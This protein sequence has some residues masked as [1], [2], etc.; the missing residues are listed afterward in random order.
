MCTRPARP[1]APKRPLPSANKR[2]APF[3]LPYAPARPGHFCIP[4]CHGEAPAPRPIHENGR[5]HGQP[6]KTADQSMETAEIMD[7]PVIPS[8]AKESISSC[9]NRRDCLPLYR[10]KN[11]DCN[12][13]IVS[14]SAF[15]IIWKSGKFQLGI[16]EEVA[17]PAPPGA[18]VTS[19]L[20][21]Q[22]SPELPNTKNLGVITYA[23]FL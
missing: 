19:S 5:N 6:G 21:T 11:C 20:C 3:P 1:V 7:S 4:S 12:R 16:S 2:P 17:K 10:C 23:F 14:F 13:H 18:G 15:R 22:K 9:I 8:E